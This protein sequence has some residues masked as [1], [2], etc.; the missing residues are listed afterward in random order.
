[1]KKAG[2]LS[3]SQEKGIDGFR[4]F[5]DTDYGNSNS[6]NNV[7]NGLDVRNRDIF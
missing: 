7:N 3:S 1:M 5:G 2:G 6:M 4:G